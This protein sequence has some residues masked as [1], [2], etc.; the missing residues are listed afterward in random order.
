MSK[1]KYNTDIEN[2]KSNMSAYKDEVLYS[3]GYNNRITSQYVINYKY[4]V[5]DNLIIN[6]NK[7]NKISKLPNDGMINCMSNF[8]RMFRSKY[9]GITIFLKILGNS[10]PTYHDIANVKSSISSISKELIKEKD[11]PYKLYGKY[12]TKVESNLFSPNRITAG[13]KIYVKR[14]K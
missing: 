6:H 7:Y 3:K 1:D 4:K 13:V 10:Y 5:Y 8:V 14:R 11:I 12:Y 2:Y 9:T